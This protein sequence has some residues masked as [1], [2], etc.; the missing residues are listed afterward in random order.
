MWDREGECLF[1]PREEIRQNKKFFAAILILAFLIL[2]ATFYIAQ[3]PILESL[4]YNSSN[5]IGG[6][7]I[8]GSGCDIFYGFPFLSRIESRGGTLIAGEL[9]SMSKTGILWEGLLA[10]E[11]IVLIASFLIAGAITVIVKRKKA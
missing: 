11:I 8:A 1:K 6:K 2:S 5:V 10:N 7:T 9:E 3:S 4:C